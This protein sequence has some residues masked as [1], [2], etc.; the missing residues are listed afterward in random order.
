MNSQIKSSELL[1]EYKTYT[2]DTT[3]DNDTAGK[4][5]IDYYYTYLLSQTNNY[6][7]EK[8]KYGSLVDAQR[9]Y[10]LFPDLIGLK[11][12]RVYDGA[13]WHPVQPVYSI[14]QWHALTGA[15]HSSNIPSHF[16]VFNQNGNLY[17]EF[18]PIPN[19]DVTDGIEFVYEGYQD[20]LIF[21][22]D[23]TTGTVAITNGSAAVTGSGTSFASSHVGRFLQ[24]SNGKYWYDIKTVGGGTSITLVNSFQETTVSGA[25][26]TIAELL[27]IPP[28]F[29]YTPVWGAAMDYYLPT[30]ATKAKEFEKKYARDLAV[31]ESRY[32][33]K[34]KGRVMPGRKVGVKPYYVPLN[35]PL[36]PIG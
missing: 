14:D 12:V 32:Q 4:R 11:N 23:Y 21:P 9:G 13:Q 28:E 19:D 16:I 20:R 1:T 36:G 34:T 2:R 24:I 30:N 17:I 25:S 8:T 5:R 6:I 7:I 22:T 35:Y 26:Y 10:L 33:G 3:T 29:A 27:R 31:I 18:D 15:A